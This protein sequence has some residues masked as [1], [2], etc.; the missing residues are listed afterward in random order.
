MGSNEQDQPDQPP[1]AVPTAKQKCI[2]QG[3]CSMLELDPDTDAKPKKTWRGKCNN[4]GKCECFAGW[5]G[6][7]CEQEKAASS[8]HGWYFDNLREECLHEERC[9]HAT[10]GAA[11]E[12]WTGRCDDSG[13]CRCFRGFK[14]RFCAP[15]GSK[16]K[17]HKMA[18]IKDEMPKSLRH[19]IGKPDPSHPVGTHTGGEYHKSVVKAK[20]KASDGAAAP[21]TK[22]FLQLLNPLEP[23]YRSIKLVGWGIAIAVVTIGMVVGG[24]LMYSRYNEMKVH[25]FSDYQKVPQQADI[26]AP[27]HTTH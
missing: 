5:T 26:W 6:D 20:A 15:E 7:R 27:V 11:A 10:S 3:Q 18:A 24:R 17:D 22:T 23:P 2:Q 4:K 13:Q 8:N 25:P 9:V 1:Q 16:Q 19:K 14:G 12:Q 21:V